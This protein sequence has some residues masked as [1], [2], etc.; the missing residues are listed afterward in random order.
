VQTVG[1]LILQS[2]EATRFRQGLGACALS[3]I[4]QFYKPTELSTQLPQVPSETP[5]A[6]RASFCATRP[7][8]DIA[9]ACFRH[10]GESGVFGYP[11]FVSPNGV[12]DASGRLVWVV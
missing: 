9:M 6:E 11:D 7:I 4:V 5:K 2:R 8:T 10:S 3:G 1:F 12:G